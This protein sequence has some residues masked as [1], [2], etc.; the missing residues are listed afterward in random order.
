MAQYPSD[1]NP[2][3]GI[4][5]PPTPSAVWPPP[6]T[7]APVFAAPEESVNTSGMKTTVPPEIASLKWNWGAF[8][9]SFLWAA[10]P[11][12]LRDV[13][14]RTRSLTTIGLLPN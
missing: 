12:G 9:L 14:I 8:L 1:N 2:A 5:P 6:P 7:N 13:R 3:G 11:V 4:P 10:R